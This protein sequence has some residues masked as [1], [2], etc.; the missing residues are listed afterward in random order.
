MK[1]G[2]RS[3][4]LYVAIAGVIV[5]FLKATCCPDFPEESLYILVTYIASRGAVKAVAASGKSNPQ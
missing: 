4:E 3:S 5:G 1:S 2:F